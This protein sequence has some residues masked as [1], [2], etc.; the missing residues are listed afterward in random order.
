M[1]GL[2][3]GWPLFK[4][5]FLSV[6][7]PAAIGNFHGR[8]RLLDYFSMLWVSLILM[9]CIAFVVALLGSFL[10]HVGIPFG[11][12]G[13]ILIGFPLAV[14]LGYNGGRSAAEQS[15]DGSAQ[16]RGAFVSSEFFG[17]KARKPPRAS[18]P[19]EGPLDPNHS[20]TLAGLKVPV[21]DEVMHFKLVGTTGTGKS[22]GISEI[23]QTALARGDRAIIATPITD[24][25]KSST[26]PTVAT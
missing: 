4:M 16:R 9:A 21:E 18:V 13:Q 1:M 14:G 10:E 26:I 3:H 19:R 20:V 5:F 8:G 22:T 17:S 7:L 11:R 2:A 6:Y 25:S 23:L 15:C 24:I 12:V